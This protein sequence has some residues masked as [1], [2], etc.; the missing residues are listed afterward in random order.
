MSLQTIFF[1]SK[2]QVW[3]ERVMFPKS[4]C[5]YLTGL[6][7]VLCEILLNY[8]M[9]PFNVIVMKNGAKVGHCISACYCCSENTLFC[10]NSLTLGEKVLF[11]WQH[12]NLTLN[13]PKLFYI[14]SWLRGCYGYN[15]V[16]RIGNLSLNRLKKGQITQNLKLYNVLEFVNLVI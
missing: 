2:K 11:Y 5:F 1:I 7:K 15:L 12:I 3:F 16:T 13:L 9:Y 14:F 10:W 4:N 6:F 8:Y